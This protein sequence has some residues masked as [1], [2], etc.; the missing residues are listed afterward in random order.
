VRK[1]VNNPV[2]TSAKFCLKDPMDVPRTKPQFVPA[3]S[4]DPQTELNGGK[5]PALPLLSALAG[6]QGLLANFTEAVVVLDDDWRIVYA[7]PAAARLCR[8]TT[9]KLLGRTPWAQWPAS[10]RTEI[11]RQHRRALRE[12]V[13]VELQHSFAEGR[14]EWLELRACSCEAGTIAYYRDITGQKRAE[15]DL[16]RRENELRDFVENAAVALRWVAEDGTILW[17]ND[18]ELKLLGYSRHEYIGHNIT[19]FHVDE[20]VVID[21]LQRLKSSEE[22]HGYESRLRCKDGS[23]RHVSISSSVYREDGRFVHTRCVTQ[24]ITGQKTIFELQGR[25]AAIVESS[26]DAILSKDLNGIIQSWNRGAERIFGYKA[27]EI[28]GKHIST[29][30]PP[31]AADEIPHILKRIARGERIDHYETRRKTKDGKILTIS[32]TVS[33]VRDGS[34]AIIGASKVARDMT[35]RRRHEQALR[36][37]NAALSQSNADLEQFAYSASHDL[38]EPL[39]MVSAYSE[40][41]KKKFGGKLGPTGDEYIGYTIQ[42]ALRMEQLLKDLRCYMQASTTR[43]EPTEDI[44]AGEVLDKATANLA[45]AIKDS[46]ASISRPDLPLVRMHEFQ[47]QQLFQN[48][49][50]N[51]IRY[52]SSEPPQIHVAAERQGSEWLFS[53]Q[54]NGIGIDPQ[55]KELVFGIFKRLHSTAEYPGTGMGLA[56]CKRVIER[57]GGRIWVESE[58]GQGSTFFFTVPCRET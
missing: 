54:D 15:S 26:D 5:R 18:A 28:V 10:A 45:A 14:E 1:L 16:L 47:L 12:R 57:A 53:V 36:E 37:A 21:V 13:P 41:L 19:E 35:E 3:D 51:S 43:Q 24:D 42:G 17:A 56:I 52:R 39:R 9:D 20:A 55:Y 38:Q 32:L 4:N 8:K 44:D 11:E 2:D 25:L 29:L 27:E 22:L 58:L 50:G 46:G 40:M 48:L 30:A 7:N 6:A 23:I 33:P 49:I 34:G 31:D